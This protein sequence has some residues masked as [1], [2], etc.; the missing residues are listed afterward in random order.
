VVVVWR[1][2]PISQVPTKTLDAWCV[3]EVPF[4]GLDAPWTRHLAGF[5]LGG[6]KAQVSTPVE[7][8]DPVSRRAVT[9]S[10]HVYELRSGPG[11]CTDAFIVWSAFV[12]INRISAARDV[13]DEVELLLRQ[14]QH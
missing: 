1:I 6:C 9:R 12:H 4:D 2:E 3:Y 11:F 7:V 10:G 13:T 5:R 14:H 8:F